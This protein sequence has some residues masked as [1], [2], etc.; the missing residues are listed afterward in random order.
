LKREG[1]ILRAERVT[2]RFKGLVAVND[3]SLAVERGSI[4]ALI[5]P[6]GAGKTTL[7]NV[8]SGF[9]R[10]DSGAVSF[11]QARIDALPPHRRSRLG[12]VR[13]FQIPRIFRRLTVIENMLVA[14][15]AQPGEGFFGC[16]YRHGGMVRRDREA[17][18]KARELLTI[19]NI[20]RLADDYA[21][22]MSGG[23]RKLLEL[24]RVLMTD[25]TMI[26]NDDPSR[27]ADG[28]RESRAR[29]SPA[30]ARRGPPPRAGPDVL[31]RRA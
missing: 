26:L 11:E 16:F 24:G 2:K 17:R 27:R 30:A 7:F 21:G 3:V 28:W 12:L 15:P 6:N 8:L 20:D 4:T 29:S 19:L 1:P 9:M 25:P 31:V 5:G 23:Q 22:S 18:D 10:A 13:T 14:D